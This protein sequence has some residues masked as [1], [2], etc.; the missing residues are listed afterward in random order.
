MSGPAES[1]QT[2]QGRQSPTSP[3]STS[4][5]IPVASRTK[6]RSTPASSQA[7]T[8]CRCDNCRRLKEKCNGGTPCDRCVKSGRNCL[9]TNAY[10]RS[11]RRPAPQQPAAVIDPKEFF[12]IERIRNLEAIVQHF[13]NIQDFSPKRLVESLD[14]SA[15]VAT[16]EQLLSWPFA[17][18]DA[19]SLFPPVDIA[20]ILLD[21]FFSVSQTNYFYVDEEQI[22][23]RISEMYTGIAA[24]LSTADAPWVCTVLMV[25]CV[26]TQFAHL[27]PQVKSR[28]SRNGQLDVASA[29]DDALALSFY[30]KSTSMIPDLLTIG[31]S[32]CVQAFI[33]MG[34]YTLPVDPAGLASSYYGMAMKIAIHN[35]M[36]LKSPYKTRDTEMSNRIWWTVYTLERR[37]SILHGRP[38]SIQRSQIGTELPVDFLELQSSGRPNTFH[39][40][41]AQKDLTEIMEMARDTIL[42]LKRADRPK[43]KQVANDALK[44]HQMLEKWWD[45]LPSETFCRDFTPARPLFR[46]NIHLALTYH[47]VHIFMGRSFIFDDFSADELSIHEW[48]TTRKVLIEHCIKSA[49][50]SIRLC[51]KLNDEFG[52]SKSSYTEFTSCCAAVVTLIAHRVLNKTADLEDICDQGIILL[53]I[54]SGGVFA[55]TKSSEKQGLEILEMAL[56]K[57]G[58]SHGESPALGGAGYDQFCT[59]VALQIDPDHSLR[60]DEATHAAGLAERCKSAPEY[61]H[62]EGTNFIPE[63]VPSTFAELMSF[64]GLENYFQYSVG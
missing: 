32:Q 2:V 42:V 41:M 55:N 48:V 20:T 3:L 6:R 46:S 56:A 15:N 34:V 16:A 63:F 1:D 10:R 47:L 51:Q 29:V 13:M 39:N 64:P 22:R 4:S 60:D 7:Y 49:I 61:S 23:R 25:F 5:K 50:S 24:P 54:M 19:V 53:K 17:I 27:A 21:V 38:A 12:D 26:S 45:N 9:F 30:R 28:H 58:T 35:N 43:L 44:V 31:S 52:L 37:V 11:R 57:L 62:I 14:Q 59:W 8:I 40:A 36:H 18:Q 33:L